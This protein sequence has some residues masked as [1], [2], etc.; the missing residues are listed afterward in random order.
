[1]LYFDTSKVSLHIDDI[2]EE[3]KT[4]QKLFD[5]ILNIKKSTYLQYDVDSSL[6]LKFQ[7]LAEKCDD[8]VNYYSKLS[9]ALDQT[10]SDAIKMITETNQLLTEHLDTVSRLINQSINIDSIDK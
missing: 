8:L 2:L 5:T 7:H 9:I 10:T 3:K 1:M 6:A 4:A